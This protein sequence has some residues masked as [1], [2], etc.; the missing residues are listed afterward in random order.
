[1]TNQ[2]GLAVVELLF[3]LI[4]TSTVF[5]VFYSIIAAYANR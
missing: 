1:M 2:K 3:F 4:A 5:L